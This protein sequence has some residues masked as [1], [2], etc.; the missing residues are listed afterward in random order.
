MEKNKIIN[1]LNGVALIGNKRG[2]E[3][4]IVNGFNDFEKKIKH[5]EDSNFWICSISKMF[6]SIAINQL[7]EKGLINKNDFMTK[8]I[9]NYFIGTNITIYH[10]L[11]HTS[12]I[13]NFIIYRKEIDWTK[14]YSS[15][16]ILTLMDRKGL[17]FKPG[18]KWSYCNTG[19]YI[20][21]LIIE[22][23]TKMKYEDYIRKNIFKVAKM[24]NSFFAIEDNKN[25]VNAN[26][27]EKHNSDFNP[28]LLFGAGDVV[29]NVKDLYSFSKALLNNDL[30]KKETLDEMAKPVFE[31]SKMKYGEGLYLNNHFNTK[32]LGH[33]GSIPMGFSTQL[34]I[35]PEKEII[36]IVLT[37]NRKKIN[38]LVLQEL[39]GKYIDSLMGE[40]IFNKNIGFMKKAYVSK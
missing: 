7:C 30:V 21:A 3:D 19:Y 36:T 9:D 2:I 13:P 11:T 37:N 6:V 39:N 12:G 20:L 27:K 38:P 5:T 16:Y 17:K 26:K 18:S 10:L 32:M 33:T 8:Y 4:I 22:K 1:K 23:V 15:D 29:S 35:Y 34:S 28:G 31:K 25:V 24:D 14:N 40:E